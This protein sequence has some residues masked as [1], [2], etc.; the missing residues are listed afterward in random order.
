MMAQA[1]V[2]VELGGIRA[3]RTGNRIEHRS[4]HFCAM[5]ATAVGAKRR[6]IFVR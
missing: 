6:H 3:N 1:T 5:M 2:L 4:Y